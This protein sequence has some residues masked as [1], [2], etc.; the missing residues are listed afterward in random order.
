MNDYTETQK[1]II[2]MAHT[3]IALV[4]IV[5]LVAMCAWLFFKGLSIVFRAVIPV[6]IGFFIALFFKPYYITTF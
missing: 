3:A 5:I 2:T 1:K 4:A 6:V